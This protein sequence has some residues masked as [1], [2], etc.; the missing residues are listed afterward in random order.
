MGR[1]FVDG[2]ERQQKV[3][4]SAGLWQRRFNGDKDIVGKSVILSGRTFTVVG[5]S[6]GLFHSIDQILYTEFWVPLGNAEQMAT[7]PF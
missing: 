4:L 2:E 1:G 5:I 7:G 6:P 3:V